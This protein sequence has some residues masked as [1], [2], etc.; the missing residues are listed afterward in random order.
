MRSTR[1]WPIIL[2]ATLLAAGCSRDPNVRKQ[3]YLKAG[4]AYF[5]KGQ[6][7]EAAIEYQN[8]I[9]IDP[10][11]AEAH[12][13]LALS[14]ERQF[15]YNAAYRELNTTVDLQPDNTQAELE[16]GNLLLTGRDFKEAQYWADTIL[17]REPNNAEAHVLR[18]NSD[19]FLSNVE[20]SLREMQTAI[21][22]TPDEGSNYLNLALLQ[23]NAKQAAAAEQ[24]FLKAVSLDPKSAMAH[25]ALAN[26][27]RAQKRWPEAEQQYRQAIQMAP[28]NPAVYASLS[29][30]LMAEDKRGD[31]EQL[32]E[33]AK[34][35]MPN[36]P[37]G[38]RLLGD[39]YFASNDLM[40]ASQEYASLA[41][42][43]PT[44]ELIEKDYIQ[45]L[46]LTN[47][48]DDAAR[49][50]DKLLKGYSTDDQALI[51]RGEI[52][53]VRGRSSEAVQ[54]LEAAIKLNPQNPFAHYHL[55]L[56]L[57]ATGDIQRASSELQ[58]AI[59][60]NPNLAQAY[61]A[62]GALATRK[63]DADLLRQAAD[64]LIS[65]RPSLPDGYLMRAGANAR[66][67]PVAAQADLK[68][69]IE[70]APQDS[71]AYVAMGQLLLDQKKYAEADKFY[72]QALSKNPR[73]AQALSGVVSLLTDQ[74]QLDR[75]AQRIQ[76]Q[77][78]KA[79]DDGAPY[80]L[81][82]RTEM[83]R[84]NFDAAEKA[85]AKA[86]ELRPTDVGV[87]QA[88]AT[89]EKARGELDAAVA[90]YQ[91]A[92]KLQPKNAEPYLLLASLK[93][94]QGQWQEAQTLYQ[95]ALEIKPGDPL[96]SNNLANI[97]LDHDGNVDVALSLAQT[98]RRAMPEFPAIADTLAW[99]YV[100]KGTYGLA[101]DL[102]EDV[103][104]KSPNDP[105]YRYHLG[106]AY[107][108]NKDDL[109]A[110]EQFERALH[111]NPPAGQVDEI[112]KALA[113]SSGD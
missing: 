14:D 1:L 92:I 59:R 5:D 71:R 94:R 4:N 90:S 103:I 96:A 21:Q 57:S 82:G 42:Q 99:A 87:L 109:H 55:G 17:G 64:G 112:R 9:H 81:L 95:K 37:A 38:Y 11:Y 104:K 47:Q 52:L 41:R 78:D 91:R 101:I 15:L 102:L 36:V 100:S 16:L 35:A 85:F 105:N 110:K 63:G 70:V 51:L 75:A 98:A 12:Y 72:E 48:L 113:K 80:V 49:L 86:L 13:R 33:Q 43:H 73:D 46:I 107:Q 39:F 3:K 74:K 20:D 108:K 84:R 89:A 54:P 106:V 22:L 66:T 61:R 30:L 28:Q 69:A 23:L 7:R 83:L 32:L 76:Q 26:F 27:Y 44:D 58:A 40:R 2:A 53:N 67:Q 65:T 45:V 19:A 25:L 50:S 111:L 10:R 79:P 29:A 34:E 8:A 88:L 77:I 56:T 24:N 68:K 6:Y 18:A 93:E 31:A 60:L 97:L 62:L